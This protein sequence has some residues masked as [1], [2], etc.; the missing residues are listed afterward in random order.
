MENHFTILSDTESKIVQMIAM[1]MSNKEI[2]IEL[3]YS[4]RMIEYYI[5]QIFKKWNVHTRVGIVAKAYQ[6]K[7]LTIHI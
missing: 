5:S 6:T 1:E 2:A 7:V 3:N 4:Q